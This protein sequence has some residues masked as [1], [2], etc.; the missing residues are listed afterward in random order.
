MLTC[1]LPP[2]TRCPI[3]R[4]R[5]CCL[6]KCAVEHNLGQ[7]CPSGIDRVGLDCIES[8]IDT[9]QCLSGMDGVRRG[10]PLRGESR[11]QHE[12]LREVTIS[13]IGIPRHCREW[14][15][16]FLVHQPVQTTLH[17]T[18]LR[19]RTWVVKKIILLKGYISWSDFQPLGTQSSRSWYVAVKSLR[20]KRISFLTTSNIIAKKICDLC[21]FLTAASIFYYFQF[22]W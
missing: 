5:L 9:R 14:H 8:M 21:D 20:D 2:L 6:L 18:P 13:E 11:R 3:C 16:V 4:H 7:M 10:I 12:V 22:R 19:S 15:V 17:F 1:F